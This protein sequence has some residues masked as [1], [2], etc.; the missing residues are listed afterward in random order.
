MKEVFSS[1]WILVVWRKEKEKRK[2]G[3]NEG[4]I[5][6]SARLWSRLS[7]LRSGRGGL[8]LRQALIR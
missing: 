3:K 2:R 4:M 1:F 8:P 5:G 7:V 6:C